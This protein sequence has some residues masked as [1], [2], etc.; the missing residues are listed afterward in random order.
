MT[1][2]FLLNP[3]VAY[4]LLVGGFLMAILALFAPGTGIIEL[5][6]L[7]SIVLA[8]ISVYYLPTNTWALIILIIGVILFL[9]SLRFSHKYVYLT[10]ATIAF[11]IGSLFLFKPVNDV[12]AI[13]PILAVF[14]STIAVS[15]MWFI[16]TKGVEA[17]S[18]K[19]VHDMERLIGMVGV[20]ETEIL[21]EGTVYI[22]GEYWTAHSQERIPENA[23]VR[24]IAREGLVLIVEVADPGNK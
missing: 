3:N 24:V 12:L 22:D 13:D 21:Q 15:F 4:V 23:H 11:I 16:G 20:A 17:S 19:P 7:F 6:A 1:I 2:D 18:R 10:L 14:V 5:V 9:L 8:G